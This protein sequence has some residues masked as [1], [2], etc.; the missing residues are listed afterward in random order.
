M[1]R[2]KRIEALRRELANLKAELRKARGAYRRATLLEE[3]RAVARELARL[4]NP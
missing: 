3:A 2:E 4:E 1:N